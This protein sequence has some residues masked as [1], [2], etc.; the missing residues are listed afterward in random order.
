MIKFKNVNDRDNAELLNGKKI[1]LSRKKFPLLKKNDFYLT[2]IIGGIAV[3]YI[4]LKITIKLF[5]NYDSR[6]LIRSNVNTIVLQALFCIFYIIL[7][8]L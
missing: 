7:L 5:N 3:A 2:D 4:G 8:L 1:H 6:E